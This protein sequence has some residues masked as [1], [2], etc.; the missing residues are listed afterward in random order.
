MLRTSLALAAAALVLAP[1][2]AGAKR[3][4]RDEAISICARELSGR[5]GGARTRVEQVHRVSRRG[6]RL[7]VHARMRVDRRG[8][9]L[10]RDVDCAVDFGGRRPRVVAFSTDRNSWGQGWGRPDTGD[11]QRASRIC[12]REAEASGWPIRNVLAVRPAERGG[13][14]V[15]LRSGVNNEVHCLYRNGVRDLRYRRR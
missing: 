3:G 6:D 11:D 5:F 8:S 15:V 4:T 1:L 14:L 13:R 2:P 12:W 9:D 10:R 7:S